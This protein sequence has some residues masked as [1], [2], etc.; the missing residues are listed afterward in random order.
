MKRVLYSDSFFVAVHRA[1]DW[2]YNIE[3]HVMMSDA[4]CGLWWR[5]QVQLVAYNSD[6]YGNMS[7]A[8]GSSNGLAIIALL[9]Q[10]SVG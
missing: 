1:L 8:V 4:V 9:G 10:V 6:L 3:A 7:Q 5:I 2:A